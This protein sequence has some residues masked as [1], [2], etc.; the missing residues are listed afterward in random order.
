M[1]STSF[2]ISIGKLYNCVLNATDSIT[3]SHTARGFKFITKKKYLH[4]F[5]FAVIGVVSFHLMHHKEGSQGHSDSDAF[6]LIVFL[7]FQG[8]GVLLRN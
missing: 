8:V 2:C 3:I 5:K 4:I 7:V 6:I 1:Y